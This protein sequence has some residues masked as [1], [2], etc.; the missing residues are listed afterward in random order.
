MWEMTDLDDRLFQRSKV[1][2]RHLEQKKIYPNLFVRYLQFYLDPEV[3]IYL[4]QCLFMDK[5]IP[6]IKNGENLKVKG[7]K[8]S[9]YD[10]YI[11]DQFLTQLTGQK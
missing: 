7:E 9:I 1:V 11:W 8:L 10:G 6:L 3:P 2:L 4:E 5:L